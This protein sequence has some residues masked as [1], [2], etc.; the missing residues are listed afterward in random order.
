MAIHRHALR[1]CPG[2]LLQESPPCETSTRKLGK[3]LNKGTPGSAQD[4][5]ISTVHTT[6]RQQ[7]VLRHVT[8]ICNLSVSLSIDTELIKKLMMIECDD[9]FA[10]VVAPS[11]A[12]QNFFELSSLSRRIFCG[13]CGWIVSP[14]FVER[15]AQNIPQ[16]NRW[17]NL[18]KSFY[19]TAVYDNL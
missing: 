4:E 17:Q 16:E 2:S 14:F 18:P 6:S 11:M 9:M 8:A 12:E 13:L 5:N 10:T 1:K 19:Y 7:T 3:C 15:S